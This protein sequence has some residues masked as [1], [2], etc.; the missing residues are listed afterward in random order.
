MYVY[1]YRWDTTRNDH[2]TYEISSHHAIEIMSSHGDNQYTGETP[3]LRIDS[4]TFQATITAAVTAVMA[5]LNANNTNENG[6]CV[7]TSNRSDNQ[8]N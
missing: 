3:I 6:I 5:Q 4:A 1:K 8:G 2:S 7:H